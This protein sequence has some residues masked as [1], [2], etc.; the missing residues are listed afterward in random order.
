MGKYEGIITKVMQDMGIPAHL[1]GYRLIRYAV[2]LLVEDINRADQIIV[3][4][5]DVAKKFNDTPSRTER[6]IRH[7]IETGWSRGD[8][9]L[10]KK[11][12]GY[13]V[14][15]NK[16]NPTNSEFLTTVADYLLMQQGRLIGTDANKEVISKIVTV[17]DSLIVALT[18][19][20]G[21]VHTKKLFDITS[22]IEDMIA[23][24]KEGEQNDRC[25]K[26]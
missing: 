22:E 10:Q 24:D 13:T 5:G 26:K 7:A 23:D 8:V 9:D 11:L 3:L 1:K 6:A 21:D 17:L 4:Y 2:E 25:N 14:D 20:M 16:D 18:P 12:F 19:E 15:Y